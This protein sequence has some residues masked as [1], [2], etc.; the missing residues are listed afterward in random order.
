[1]FKSRKKTLN[2]SDRDPTYKVRYV[3]NVL[4]AFMRGDGC[5]D[6]PVSILWNNYDSNPDDALD[7]QLTIC[8]S[9]LKARTK[10]SGL[11]EYRSHRISYC[12]CHPLYPRLFAWVYRH[13]GKKM[14]VELRCHAVLCKS[15]AVAKAIAVQLHDKL[16]FVLSEFTKE[17]TR[18]QRARLAIQRANCAP[19]GTVGPFN[20]SNTT[21]V[22]T[23]RTKF[24][25]VGQ[26]F[27]PPS[28]QSAGAPKLGSIS[29]DMEKKM[30]RTVEGEAIKRDP[31]EVNCSYSPY[32]EE[33]TEVKTNEE[34]QATTRKTLQK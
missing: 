1:M 25:T 31:S 18:R 12:V 16:S 21:A 15:D 7:M 26:N 30:T 24:L 20:P 9:G 19:N 4:T 33:Q 3:G 29:E 28:D 5:V 11:T 27:K 6:R 13:E 17:R 22:P 32:E 14:K 8:A 23:I 10:D 34:S 2:I